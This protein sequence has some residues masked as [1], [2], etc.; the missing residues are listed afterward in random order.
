D[1]PACAP[2]RAPES[3]DTTFTGRVAYQWTA[4]FRFLGL[5]SDDA[6]FLEDYRSNLARAVT[7]QYAE[8]EKDGRRYGFL[9]DKPLTAPGTGEAGPT[10]TNGFYDAENLYRLQRDTGDAPIGDPALPPSRVLAAV[11]RTLVELGAGKFGDGTPEGIWP[12]LLA[13]TWKGP[14][15]GGALQTV[16]AKDRELYNPE[17]YGTVAL[18]VR[19]GRQTGDPVLIKAGDQ[20]I[21]TILRQAKGEVLPL[22]KIQGQTLTR[23][24]AAVAVAAAEPSPP[25]R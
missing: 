4:V 7:V 10:W 23:L 16:E 22:G 18:L 9:G 13:Y 21:R 17:K 14:R 19:T 5:A 20:M 2:S 11:A 3:P 6:S 12:R 8:L 24:H 15:I 1:G 25:R